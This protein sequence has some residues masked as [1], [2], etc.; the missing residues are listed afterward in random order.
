MKRFHSIGHYCSNFI[1]DLPQR[2]I[3]SFQISKRSYHIGL[4]RYQIPSTLTP[5]ESCKDKRPRRASLLPNIYL[6]GNRIFLS[7]SMV[8]MV[9]KTLFV[10][11]QY[12]YQRQRTKVEPRSDWCSEHPFF[13]PRSHLSGLIQRI[14]RYLATTKGCR[15]R[16]FKDCQLLY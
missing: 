2:M 4:F 3:W 9:A 12:Y 16:Y 8:R 11:L 10:C 13:L 14:G 7:Y 15:M 6:M 5:S 1:S